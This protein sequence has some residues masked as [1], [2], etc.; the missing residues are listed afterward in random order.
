MDN[1]ITTTELSER[2]DRTASRIIKVLESSGFVAEHVYVDSHLCKAWSPEAV[3]Y[4][5]KFIAEE[6][7]KSLL[8][9]DYAKELGVSEDLF[10]TA[11]NNL[12]ISAEYRTNRNKLLEK[13]I[14]RLVEED[15][16]AMYESHPLV[17]NKKFFKASYF[18]DVVPNCFEDLNEDII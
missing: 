3:D 8:I 4:F 13:E 16:T 10:R 9:M 7:A 1:Y 15:K 6:N 2:Y 12:G 18:P 11:M 5:D 17:T 14:K